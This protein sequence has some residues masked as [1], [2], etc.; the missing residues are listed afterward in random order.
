MEE[1]IAIGVFVLQ[2]PGATKT[3]FPADVETA[4]EVVRFVLS[5]RSQLVGFEVARD[6]QRK[7]RREAFVTNGIVFPVA[8]IGRGC[9]RRP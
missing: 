5:L 6:R 1:V 4:I 2:A 9:G 7:G 3:G 8:R